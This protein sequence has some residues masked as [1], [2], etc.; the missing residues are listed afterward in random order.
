MRTDSSLVFPLIV[1]H[2]VSHGI[3]NLKIICVFH[4]RIKF[5]GEITLK[6]TTY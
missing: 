1:D 4:V 2:P 3:D 6:G 5:Y